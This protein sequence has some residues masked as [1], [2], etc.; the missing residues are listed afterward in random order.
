MDVIIEVGEWYGIN[1]REKITRRWDRKRA[2]DLRRNVPSMSFV[3]KFRSPPKS[4]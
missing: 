1:W 2:I 3:A 4:R